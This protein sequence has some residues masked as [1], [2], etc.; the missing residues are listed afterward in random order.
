MDWNQQTELN[1]L[2]KKQQLERE[3]LQGLTSRVKTLKQ[4]L[5]EADS[6]KSE[7]RRNAATGAAFS[8]NPKGARRM[9]ELRKVRSQLMADPSIYFG[10][11]DHAVV[12]KSWQYESL[13]DRQRTAIQKQYS[14]MVDELIEEELPAIVNDEWYLPLKE[15]FDALTERE[16]EHFSPGERFTMELFEELRGATQQPRFVDGQDVLFGKPIMA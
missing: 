13:N 10:T 2:E 3:A 4:K 11:L 5:K 15:A 14:W 12:R 7:Y 16:Q 9:D 6:L 8:Y 1:S